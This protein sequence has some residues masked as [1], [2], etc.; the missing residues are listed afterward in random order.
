MTGRPRGLREAPSLQ[1]TRTVSV[2]FCSWDGPTS[3]EALN[4]TEASPGPGAGTRGLGA[5]L[6]LLRA[7]SSLPGPGS[8]QQHWHYQGTRQGGI[9]ALRATEV[10]HLGPTAQP[11]GGRGTS[12]G[13]GRFRIESLQ[14]IGT[15]TVG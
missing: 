2:C 6:L 12:M 13:G 9:G 14:T 4:Q 5:T 11:Y 1:G 15:D 8:H 7:G 10:A 3:Q